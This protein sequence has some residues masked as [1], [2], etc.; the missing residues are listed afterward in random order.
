[1]P[2]SASTGGRAGFPP[3]SGNCSGNAQSA[4]L[5]RLCV[6]PRPGEGCDCPRGARGNQTLP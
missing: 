3:R 4:T 6:L 5:E 1:M 2:R